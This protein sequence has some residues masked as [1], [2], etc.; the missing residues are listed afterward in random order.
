MCH[1]IL[2]FLEHGGGVSEMI[3]TLGG[4]EMKFRKRMLWCSSCE[5][6]GCQGQSY[7][8]GNYRYESITPFLGSRL[9]FSISIKLESIFPERR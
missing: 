5:L 3:W 9:G 2:N 1:A 8:F 7:T 4:F 6:V